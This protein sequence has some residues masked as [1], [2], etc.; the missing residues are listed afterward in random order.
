MHEQVSKWVDIFEKIVN[1]IRPNAYNVIAK[2]V[3]GVGLC[4]I[5]ESQVKI[6]HAFAIALFEEYV[7]KSE[8]L[9]AFLNATSDPTSGIILVLSGLG[10]HLIATIGKGYI[11]TRKA[12]LPKLPSLNCQLLNG[13]NEVLE[14][15]F[16]I[17]GSRVNLPNNDDI[18]DYKEDKPDFNHPI[19][20]HLHIIAAI[21][22]PNFGKHRNTELFRERAKVL[23][24][25]AGA[26]LLYLKITNDSRILASGVSIKL[27][28]PRHKGLSVTMPGKLPSTPQKDIDDFPNLVP[29]Y[30]RAKHIDP[31]AITLHSEHNFYYISW[32]IS[33]MQAQTEEVSTESILL[34]TDKTV[35]IECTIFCDELPEPITTKYKVHPSLE[36]IDIDVEQLI[37][38][39]SYNKISDKLI[40]DG[41]ETRVFRSLFEQREMDEAR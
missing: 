3:I 6:A 38:G 9:R 21:Q 19:F 31:K 2:W 40:M 12:E 29:H 10:Y 25:W 24:E 30:Q 37:D 17:R 33:K 32:S 41:Y 36:I 22:T 23:S 28:I 4:Q 5:A 18:P 14:A 39:D 34:K 7:S 16:T 8:I 35:E 11:D 1:L 20:G 26:E 13:D 27:E 15:Q